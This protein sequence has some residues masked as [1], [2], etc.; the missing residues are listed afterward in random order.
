MTA[1]MKESDFEADVVAALVTSGGYAQGQPADFDRE[2]GLDPVA[3]VAWV[4]LS[5][6][7]RF[8]QLVVRY[9]GDPAMAQA[10]FA[11]RVSADIARR[12]VIAVLREGVKDQGLAFDL[13]SFRPATS[14]NP[15]HA[16]RYAAN[17]LTVTRQLAYSPKHAG[18]VDLG[19]FLNGI[20]IAT[21]ELKNQLTGQKVDH[22]I[23]QYM[24]DRDPKDPV[25]RRALV[26]FSVD[27]YLVYI[28]TRLAAKNTEFLPFNRGNNGGK[29]N[30]PVEAGYATSYLWE[31]IWER[32]A[33]LDIL[34]RFVTVTG[35][36]DDAQVL[37]PRYHQWDV[38]RRVEADAKANGPG[39]RYLIQHSAGSGKSNSIGWLAHR[40]SNLHDATDTKVFDKVVVI[41]DRRVLDEQLRANV[42]AFERVTGTVTTITG[43]D[44]SKSADLAGALASAA[45]KIVV[46]TLQ[47]FP[48]LLAL[49][50]DS[51]VSK[52]RYAVII[53]EA[54]SSQTGD[55]AAA[56]RQ[57][58]GAGVELEDD[59]DAEEALAALLA[60]RGPQPNLSFFAFT[61]TPKDR[62]I[63]VFGSTQPDATK[64]PFHL[65]SMRQAIEETFILDV[66]RN[67]L[68]YKAYF[69]L[70]VANDEAAGKEV[71][72]RKAGAALRRLVVRDPDV[73]A[74]KAKIMVEHFRGHTATKIGGLAKAMVVTDSRASAV[75]YKR[76][77]DTYIAECH[78]TD[79]RTLVAFSGTVID[80]IAGPVTESS[81]NGFPDGQTASRFKGLPPHAP[82]DYHVLIVAEKFQTGF[83]EPLLHTMFV[84]KTLVG[85]ATVQTLSRLNRK[86]PE[87]WDTFV[88]DFRNDTESVRKD[89]QRYYEATTTVPTDANALT[90]AYDRVTKKWAV[91][92]PGEMASVVATYFTGTL[93]TGGLGGVY[94]AFDPALAR[95]GDLDEQDRADFRAALD[96]FLHLHS[97]MSQVLLWV[98]ADVERGYLFGKALAHLL[99]H[100]ATGSLE[101]GDDV[102]LTHLRLEAQNEASIA[103]EVGGAEPGSA[104]PG[105][106]IGRL[107]DPRFGT[108]GEITDELN[109]HFALDLTEVHRLAFAQFEVTWLGDKD[110]RQIANANTMD[111]FRLEFERKFRDTLLDTKYLNDDLYA[112]IW[113]KPDLRSRIVDYYV[114]HMYRRLRESPTPPV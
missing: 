89:F 39:H 76:A 25:L 98:D 72:V 10:S 26:H 111:G 9:G 18:A 82:G 101:L 95:F 29:G 12:G 66:L 109:K 8:A 60:S 53:D 17:R 68:P 74:A 2:L 48:F 113:S 65:Y 70:A 103:L 93:S 47:V 49:P 16:A 27:Q 61:A 87:K 71:E 22:A 79:I 50:L 92:D 57:A 105:H 96:G 102:L 106:G 54:H 33:W 83:D 28:T 21:A 110:L 36:G 81:L 32:E 5:Q 80:D 52:R 42:A 67:Y 75:R 77:I 45:T 55:A 86:H 73:I 34:S 112:K 14:M 7:E 91:L 94:S 46:T 38:V 84:D 58:L 99:P 41:T 88:L 35:T 85:L 114:G 1:G 24:T 13:A 37:F 63:E 59:M 20:L 51:D 78:Y 40:L 6:V 3:L 30:S 64:G 97:F 100:D 15:T 4:T 11:R 43:H 44:M 19:L 107:N 104:F 31:T 108:L 23:S 62:T 69:R 56:L 90:D